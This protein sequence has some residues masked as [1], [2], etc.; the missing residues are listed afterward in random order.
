[1]RSV[2]IELTSYCNA[3]CNICPHK[4][5][6]ETPRHIPFELFKQ[7]I[8]ACR[9]LIDSNTVFGPCG[10]GE[11]LLYP[12]LK[13][14]IEYLKML[15]PRNVV[16]LNT[17]GFSLNRENS[18]M[19]L[20]A[21]SANDVLVISLNADSAASYDALMNC[22]KYELVVENTREFLE[23]HRNRENT[24]IV[25]LRFLQTSLTSLERF[26]ESWAQYIGPN[27]GINSYSLLNWGGLISAPEKQVNRRACLSLWNCL[28]FDV[29]GN[30]YPC[31]EALAT[32]EKSSLL[33][34]NIKCD[35]VVEAYE[36]G[37]SVFRQQHLNNVW[38]G[39]C[40]HC[41]FWFE[42]S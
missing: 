12:K 26:R 42:S 20:E 23:L 30:F 17:N 8:E 21:L 33:L 36:R 9:S 16:S 11:P 13:A 31:C 34:G 37:V 1:M 18:R 28:S 27:V 14:A 24:C 39:D 25:V 15:Y 3:A 35:N 4:T 10:L 22:G 2:G 5:V 19:I 6:I 32:R 40:E 29:N 41:D 7:I 38:V